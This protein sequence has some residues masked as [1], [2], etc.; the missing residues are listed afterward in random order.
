MI[1]IIIIIFLSKISHQLTRNKKPKWYSE[2]QLSLMQDFFYLY[3]SFEHDSWLPQF[4]PFYYNIKKTFMY[5]GDC[6]FVLQ[7][8]YLSVPN[9]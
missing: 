9:K 3:K 7:S 4:I 2:Y 6:E 5:I 8:V 1:M